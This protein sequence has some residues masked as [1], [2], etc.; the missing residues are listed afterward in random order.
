MGK[1]S[2]VLTQGDKIYSIIKCETYI[3]LELVPEVLHFSLESLILLLGN[4]QLLLK[5]FSHLL[6]H[7]LQEDESTVKGLHLAFF[8][9]LQE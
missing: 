9:F 4:H 8:F 5:P 2:V 6:V 1:E 7:S 3:L